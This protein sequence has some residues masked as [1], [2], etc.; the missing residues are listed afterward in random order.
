MTSVETASESSSPNRSMSNEERAK[1]RQHLLESAVGAIREIGPTA[2]MEDIATA[3]GVTKPILYRHF[4]DRSGLMEAIGQRYVDSLLTRIME[5]MEGAPNDTTWATIDAF[6]SVLED[7]P[8]LYAF[9]MRQTATEAGAEKKGVIIE[10]ISLAIADLIRA[11]WEAEG[12][13]VSS[14]ETIAF[15]VVGMVH[16]AG[17]RWVRTG[18]ADRSEIT[19]NLTDLLWL[20]FSGLRAR[21]EAEVGQRR[22][23]D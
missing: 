20:G 11:N 6:L 9:L 3:G 23:V 16:H 19:T 15:G 5:V 7:D 17:D 22:A 18:G 1:Q 8:N 4:G 12:R 10:M 14:V 21:H 13:D 2:S